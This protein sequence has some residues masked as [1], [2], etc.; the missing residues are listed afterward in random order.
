MT[1]N[2]RSWPSFWNSA[3]FPRITTTLACCQWCDHQVCKL[4]ATAAGW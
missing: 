1:P 2:L 4:T 3:A